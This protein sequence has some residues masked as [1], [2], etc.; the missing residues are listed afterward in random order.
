MQQTNQKQSLAQGAL[1]SKMV[2]FALPVMLTGTLQLLYNAAD[3]VVVGRFAGTI[4]QSAVGSTTSLVNLLVNAFVGLS[5]GASVV[6]SNQLGAKDEGAVSQTVHTSMALALVLGF[7]CAIFGLVASPLMLGWMQTPADVMEKSVLYLRIFFL[8]MPCN[9]VANFGFAML[10][11]TGDSKRPLRYLA[12][13]GLVNVLLNL[14]LVAV[15]HFDVAGVA[16]GTIAAQTLCAIWVVGH[17]MKRTD[18]LRF[19]PREWQVDWARIKQITRIG[20]PASIQSMLF[21]TS[22]VLVQSTVNTFGGAAMA[23]D[24]NA[25]TIIGFMYLAVN[26]VQQ[27]ATVFA[28]QNMG[29]SEYGR[30]RRVLR[31]SALLSATVCI[32]LA[33]VFTIFATQVLSLYNTDP[34]VIAL[35]VLKLHISVPLYFIF[36]LNDTL[37]GFLRGMGY[38]YLPTV[39]SLCGVCLLRVLWVAFVFPLQPTLTCL[40]YAY[41]VTWCVALI[42]MSVSVAWALKRL[43]KQLNG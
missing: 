27:T 5:I 23:A 38:S 24:A 39:V 16:I 30:V 7:I 3:I 6:L 19:N 25:G 28:S 1:F 40:Y 9:M 8:G 33:V 14:I 31:Y 42:G 11:A 13:S 37:G 35:G 17:L 4:A 21:S 34:E 32:S 22:N 20:I 2:R 43:P 12:I 26:A 15:F 41:P 36:A 29:A 10:R 18:A